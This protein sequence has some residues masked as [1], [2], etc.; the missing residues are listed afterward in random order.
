MDNAELLRL[1]G[2]WGQGFHEPQFDGQFEVLQQRLLA[3]KHLKLVLLH[4]VT[5][6]QIDAIAFNVDRQQWPTQEKYVHAV[7]RLDVN[8]YRGLR[9]VQLVIEALQ[10][11]ATL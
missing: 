10:P 4:P 2:P 3:D 9:T 11:L 1:H 7:Y 8:D 5:R 6:S